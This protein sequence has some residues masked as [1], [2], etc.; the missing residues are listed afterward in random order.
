MENSLETKAIEYGH[1]TPRM[2]ADFAAKVKGRKLCLTHVSPRY[3]PVSLAKEG[4]NETAQILLA[5]A[6]QRLHEK[7]V[8]NIKVVIAEDFFED[9]IKYPET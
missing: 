4:D 9:Q 2:A 7:D 5:E 1:S 3:K 6:R 8:F